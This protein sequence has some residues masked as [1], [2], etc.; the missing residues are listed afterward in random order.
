MTEQTVLLVPRGW[1][2]ATVGKN[3]SMGATGMPVKL[4]NEFS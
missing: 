3:V 2:I 1:K 4:V